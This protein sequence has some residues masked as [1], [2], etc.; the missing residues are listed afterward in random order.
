MCILI[1]CF[2]EKAFD[3][4]AAVLTATAF[5]SCGKSGEKEE[6]AVPILET[7]DVT[8]KTERAEVS[9]I[10]EK[11]YQKGSY[12][13]PYYEFVSFKASGQIE[14]LNVETDTEVKKRRSALRFEY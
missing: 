14:T 4:F 1:G 12:G 8:Y 13:Y 7:K 5:S 6:I 2:Y 11:Y 3:L 10:S 9:D